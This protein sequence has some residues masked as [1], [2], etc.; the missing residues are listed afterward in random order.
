MCRTESL[1]PAYGGDYLGLD[2]F[3][4][5][6]VYIYTYIHIYTYT[7]QC[8]YLLP[9]QY[10]S[11]AL[12]TYC[13]MSLSVRVERRCPNHLSYSQDS[14]Y[15]W[16]VGPYSGWIY[17][18]LHTS[19]TVK[20]LLN[21]LYGIH[22]LSRAPKATS[23]SLQLSMFFC[24]PSRGPMGLS[25][26]AD[27]TV[28]YSSPYYGSESNTGPFKDFP[29]FGMASLYSKQERIL[30]TTPQPRKRRFWATT[31]YFRLQPA[32]CIRKSYTPLSSP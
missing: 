2:L 13:M 20:S 31:S 23:R 10:H 22:V 9:Y 8:L 4:Y 3:F 19:I 6:C 29:H 24:N 25:F 12:S 14:G 16:I 17:I 18:R 7:Y 5:I 11:I 15:F 21:S 30:H 32:L 27:N 26:N 1:K 28:L